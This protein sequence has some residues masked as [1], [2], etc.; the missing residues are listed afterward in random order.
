RRGTDIVTDID[1][2]GG[3]AAGLFAGYLLAREGRR[4]RLFDAND[5][6]NVDSRTLI[7][8]SRLSDV[9]GFFPHEA[10]VNQIDQIDLYSPNRSVTVPMQ[11]PDLV[12]ER[13]AVVRLLAKKA[14]DAGVEIRG[15]CKLVDVTR[16]SAGLSLTIRDTH[17][18]RT[19]TVKT[20]TLIG[21]DG[22]SS[23]VAKAAKASGHPTTPL[24]Q[25]IVELPKG[26]RPGTTKV[27]FEPNDTPYF[28]WLIPESSTRAAVGFIAE[29]GKTARR[30]LERFLA[31]IGLKALDM[32]SARIP[33][34]AHSM[35]P[36]RRIAGCEVYLVGD[37]A[38]QV[39]V[40]TV[41]G[42][43]TGLR[44]ARAAA[45]AILRR[46]DFQDELQSLRRELSLHLMMRNALNRFGSDDYD[47]LLALLNPKTIQLLGTYNRDHAATVLFRIFLAQPRLLGF[48]HLLSR[49]KFTGERK[50]EF[51]DGVRN[52]L[53]KSWN[54]MALL[55]SPR[56][57]S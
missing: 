14:V 38:A 50:L 48:A 47:K 25:A 2:I 36:W 55:L 15:G 33:A 7:T 54:R 40:T 44:G 23:R 34:Y 18:D 46:A 24:L 43:V 16:G 31:R 19:E 39:K 27:W 28:Y 52:I 41:G 49:R 11:K 20:K 6:L 4:V 29:D 45:N 1:I 32:Q 5:V 10:I 37:A 56:T 30:T 57:F 8:T 42:L 26:S 21:A 13:A 9:L 3:S 12:V 53:S 51:A 17:R 22:M 35:R